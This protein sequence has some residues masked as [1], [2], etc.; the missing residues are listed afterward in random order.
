[1]LDWPR[2]VTVG[3]GAPVVVDLRHHDRAVQVVEIDLLGDGQPAQRVA[4][5]DLRG[6]SGVWLMPGRRG[7]FDLQVRATDSDGCQG[8]TGAQRRVTVR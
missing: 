4:G 8:S 7:Q 5:I 1:M 6:V 3:V 2:T